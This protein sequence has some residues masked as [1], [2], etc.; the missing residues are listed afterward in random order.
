MNKPSALGRGLGS[1]IPQ[2]TLTITEA[3]IPT[4]SGRAVLE[5]APN[6]IKE[7]PRQPRKDFAA[8]D[9]EDLIQS[10]KRHGILL[11]LVVTRKPDG[12]FELVAG[13]RR[14]RAARALGLPTVP[15]IVRE[16]T[17]QQKLELA[18]IEN[19]QRADLNAY[20]EALAYKALVDEFGLT[21]EDTAAR[22]GK[23]RS[24]VANTMRLLDLPE[25]MVSALREGKLSK[26]HARTLLSEPDST[27]RRQLF[28]R[29]LEG[30]VTVREAEAVSGVGA[31][32]RGRPPR[33]ANVAEL[34]K[35]LREALATKVLI[36]HKNG[37]GKISIA[38][39]STEELRGLVDQLSNT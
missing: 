26:S 39:Y 23:S 35:K 36:S 10:V 11:P 24:A 6:K 34:E 33:D 27:K 13:E 38:F 17:E 28:L 25:E 7:N 30:G 22:V 12:N 21:Q 18:I 2:K 15:A 19:V 3:I 31:G 20:E 32:R 8:A 4:E 5:I 9:L 16:A 29:M 37:R 1:L 14:L